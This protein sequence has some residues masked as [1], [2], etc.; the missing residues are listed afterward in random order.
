[1]EPI[2]LRAIA[3]V[4]ARVPGRR[5][6]DTGLDGRVEYAHCP[7]NQALQYPPPHST[8]LQLGSAKQRS[9]HVSQSPFDRSRYAQST[10][11]VK[12]AQ[13]HCFCSHSQVTLAAIT[14]TV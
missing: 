1:M 2:Q 9:L 6:V 8:A 3:C 12:S 13:L 7:L 5:H 14:S 11:S 10:F 4:F